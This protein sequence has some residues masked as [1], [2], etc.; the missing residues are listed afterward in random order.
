VNVPTDK[1]T[2]DNVTSFYYR[3]QLWPT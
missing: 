2:Q 3:V 1:T